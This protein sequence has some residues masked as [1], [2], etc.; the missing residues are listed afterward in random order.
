LVLGAG[1]YGHEAAGEGAA[2]AT[3]DFDALAAQGLK[4]LGGGGVITHAQRKGF[5]LLGERGGGVVIDSGYAAAAFVKDGKGLEDVVEL[6]RG[7]VDGD[8]LVVG[9]GAGVFKVADAVF[10][11]DDLADGKVFDGGGGDGG[12]G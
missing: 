8:A 12:G 4:E 5:E 11:E 1:F 9:D 3:G 10:V 7:E 2:G 6:G